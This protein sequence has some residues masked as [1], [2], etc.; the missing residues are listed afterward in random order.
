MKKVITS[1]AT[2]ALAGSV[3]AANESFIYHGFEENNPDLYSGYSEEDTRTAVQPGIGDS[4]D[5]STSPSSRS[6]DSYGDWVAKNPD[7]YSGIGSAGHSTAVQPG[8]GDFTDNIMKRKLDLMRSDSYDA[9]VAGNPDQA[10]G[11]R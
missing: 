2:L 1:I 3:S 4:S 8:V 9:W 5:R 11:V 6:T 7:D 10:S